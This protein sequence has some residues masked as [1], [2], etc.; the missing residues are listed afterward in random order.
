MRSL[1]LT[2]VLFLLTCQFGLAQTRIDG[3]FAFQTNSAKE[4][5]LYIPSGYTA[6]TPNGMMLGMHP[7]NTSRWNAVSWCDT[8]IDFAEANNLLLVCPDGGANGNVT[9]PIDFAFTTALLDS[10]YNWY[11]VDQARIYIMGFSFGGQA[12]YTYGLDHPDVFRGL[13]PIGAAITGT[14]EVNQPL[15]DNAECMP[16]YIVHGGNDSPNNRYWPVRMALI[17]NGALLNSILMPGVGHTI[18]FPNRNQILGDAFQWIDS[19]NLNTPVPEAYFGFVDNALTVTFEDSSAHAA[20]WSWDFGD[21]NSST[22][23]SPV[24]TYAAPGSYTVCLTVTNAAG[25]EANYCAAVQ[26]V[27]TNKEEANWASM[28]LYPNPATTSVKLDWLRPLSL[29]GEMVI[30]DLQGRLV[31]RHQL[32]SGISSFNFSVTNLPSGLYLGT[33]A[34]QGARKSFKLRVTH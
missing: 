8:L 2:S 20:S 6:G 10:M 21:G 34:L 25:C 9:D 23:E 5:S 28:H 3:N 13:I 33:L 27:L 11:T 22:M 1:L 15:L 29:E 19:V 14:N 4:Y 26:V 18:D 16:V 32:P 24:H 30:H 17:N 7:L 12:T 31:Q